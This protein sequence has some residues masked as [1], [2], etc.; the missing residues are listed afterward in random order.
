MR[1]DI[2]FGIISAIIIGICFYFACRITRKHV[3]EMRKECD[4]IIKQKSDDLEKQYEILRARVYEQERNN[5][6]H[7]ELAKLQEKAD[8]DNEAYRQSQ[9]RVIS[10]ELDAR[11]REAELEY[12]N[13]V[14]KVAKDLTHEENM[15]KSLLVGTK[16]EIQEIT[17]KLS[18]LRTERDNVIAALKAEEELN[19]NIAFHSFTLSVDDKD[20]IEL[21]KN[22]MH[23]MHKL[24]PIHKL[25][26]SEYYQRIYGEMADRILGKE[27]ITGIYKITHIPSKKCYIGQAVDVRTRW[28]NHIKTALHVDGGAAHARFHDALGSLGL[29]NF[30]WELLEKCPKEKLNE[31]EKFYIEFYKSNDW[32]WNSNSGVGKVQT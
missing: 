10:N 21:L 5:V 27:K 31:R 16:T 1:Y 18:T 6:Y 3:D 2:I 17:N 30:T 12:T 9:Y 28:A 23:R 7:N 22:L 32:G 24:A 29:E 25:I 14:D 11:K 8:A 4:R 19:N 26:W 20:D 15:L 13:Y